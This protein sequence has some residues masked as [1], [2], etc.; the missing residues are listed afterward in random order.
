MCFAAFSRINYNLWTP[1]RREKRAVSVFMSVCVCVGMYFSLIKFGKQKLQ[2]YEIIHL[3]RLANEMTVRDRA[4]GG[5]AAKI[6]TAAENNNKNRRRPKKD[7]KD[8]V[9]FILCRLKYARH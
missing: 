5:K 7:R 8:F 1:Q 6:E 3:I 9:I 2:A 4:L